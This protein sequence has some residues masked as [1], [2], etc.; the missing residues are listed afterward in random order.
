MKIKDFKKNLK[1]NAINVSLDDKSQTIIQEIESLPLNNHFSE[2]K[3]KNN[4]FL[5]IPLA[6]SLCASIGVIAIGVITGLN[7]GSS[8]NKIQLSYAKQVASLTNFVVS[9][10]EQNLSKDK[11]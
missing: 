8:P 9:Q 5:F 2:P 7:E 10:W 1:E 4:S 6:V 11:F 3:K